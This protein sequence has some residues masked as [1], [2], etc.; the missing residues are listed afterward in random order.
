MKFLG[1]RN[2]AWKSPGSVRFWMISPEFRND[3]HSISHQL[4]WKVFGVGKNAETPTGLTNNAARII[5]SCERLIEKL[6]SQENDQ[7]RKCQLKEIDSQVGQ[8]SRTSL[9]A[10]HEWDGK[11][12]TQ[13]PLWPKSNKK[14]NLQMD[15]RC[16]ELLIFAGFPLR[17]YKHQGPRL[18]SFLKDLDLARSKTEDFA[19]LSGSKSESIGVYSLNKN[20]A[21]L[22]ILLPSATCTT[23]QSMQGVQALR[24]I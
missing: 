13:A 18:A 14:W 6:R 3:I 5:F 1:G 20:R 16:W 23:L 8:G 7:Q 2:G 19:H 22:V 4:R 10:S 24:G 9:Q 21:E 15:S 12:E 11:A 17:W